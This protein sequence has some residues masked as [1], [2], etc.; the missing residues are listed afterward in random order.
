MR[1]DCLPN[2]TDSSLVDLMLSHPSALGFSGR[3]GGRAGGGGHR[4][5]GL[6]G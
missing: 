5:A 4:L 1:Y 2:T 6:G 3:G